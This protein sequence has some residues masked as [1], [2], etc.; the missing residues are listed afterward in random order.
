MAIEKY[1]KKPVEVEGVEWT[2]KNV[3]EIRQFCGRRAVFNYSINPNNVDEEE[4]SL[5]IDTLEG[6]M[7]VRV[8]DYI[9][10]GVDGEVY[11]IYRP[12]FEKMYEKMDG[13]PIPKLVGEEVEE[14][15]E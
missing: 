15:D 4:I 5:V 3:G 6:S 8:H 2:G 14:E 1:K 13:S 9:L 12:A 11:P 10:K 7:R